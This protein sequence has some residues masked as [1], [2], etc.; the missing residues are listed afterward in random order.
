MDGTFRQKNEGVTPPWTVALPENAVVVVTASYPLLAARP[1]DVCSLRF[2]RQSRDEPLRVLL[3][4]LH[5]KVAE[6]VDVVTEALRQ[7]VPHGADLFNH[8]VRRCRFH[9]AS[10]SSGV[11]TIGGS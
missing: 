7:L 5:E 8:R 3:L 2:F 4:L 6:S 1:H 10:S 9:G 11:Q